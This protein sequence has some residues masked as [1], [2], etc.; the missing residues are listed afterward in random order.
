[1]KR[2]ISLAAA[3]AVAVMTAGSILP[4]RAADSASV[5]QD[6][7][8]YTVYSDHAALTGHTDSVS[9][10]L[11]VPETVASVPV[12]T[13]GEDALWDCTEVTSV[14]LPDSVTVIDEMAFCGCTALKKVRIGQSVTDIGS[15]AFAQSGITTLGTNGVD[16][17]VMLPDSVTSV[18][19]ACFAD[20]KSIGFANTGSGLYAIP[21]EMFAGCESLSFLTIPAGPK[22]VGIGAFSGCTNLHLAKLPLTV[23][24]VGRDAFEGCTSLRMLYVYAPNCTIDDHAQTLYGGSDDFC[25][26]GQADSTAQAYAEKYGYTF[27]AIAA[28]TCGEHLTWEL[29]SEGT[30][31]I[32]GTGEMDI[33][34]S[35]HAPWYDRRDE[36]KKVTVT[37]GVTSIGNFAFD[38]APNLTQVTLPKSVE[39]VSAAAF[40][41]CASLESIEIA[42]PDCTIY[43]AP[44]TISNGHEDT[45]FY[46][47]G[48]IYG[49]ADSTAQT[50]AEQYGY[51]FEPFASGTFGDDLTWTYE[52]GVLTI[53]GT[54]SMKSDEWRHG[55][56][57][58]APWWSFWPVIQKVVI[59]EGATDIGKYAFYNCENLTSVSI[60]DTVTYIGQCAFFQCTSLPSITLPDSLETLGFSALGSCTS[61]TTV[62][63]PD[64]VKE[65]E[66]YEFQDCSGLISVQLPD[67]LTSIGDGA[68]YNCTSLTS[69][70]IP[71]SV[72]GIRSHT[73]V[74]CESLTSVTLPDSVTTIGESAFCYCYGLKSITIPG[75]VTEF[76]N[77]YVFD[78]CTDLTIRGYTGSAA[79]R[80]AEIHS[81]PFVSIGIYVEPTEPPTE[82]PTEEPTQAPIVEP[83]QAPTTAPVEPTQ[84]R[85]PAPPPPSPSTAMRTGITTATSSTSSPSTRTSSAPPCSM[86]RAP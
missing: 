41:C 48:T 11:I 85:P 55:D 8:V 60:P 33:F 78:H 16:P 6:D 81:I 36:I 18:G 72:T 47:N 10:S 54:G 7:L 1:M 21:A 31:I 22:S 20:C 86:H 69:I 63:I 35:E 2:F 61:L 26:Y 68:F 79:E 64:S 25:I 43:D 49:Y 62:T 17:G 84:S 59:E 24:E 12:T 74:S 9:G 57:Y 30:L 50:Y 39:K 66:D 51:K 45:A 34:N 38:S 76:R 15:L 52:S 14:W 65:I 40:Y 3:C 4:V 75:S 13:V 56:G 19:S 42:N 53:S 82:E 71:D 67:T 70:D 32:R 46:F 5:T 80:Y 73:F 77:G 58:R 44:S 28:G 27:N 83:T 29:T 23:Q 37:D